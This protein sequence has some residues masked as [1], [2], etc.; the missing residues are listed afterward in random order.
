MSFVSL[1]EKDAYKVTQGISP[2][3][4]QSKKPVSAALLKRKVADS[5]PRIGHFHTITK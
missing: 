3:N 2:S 5:I 4:Q 1:T